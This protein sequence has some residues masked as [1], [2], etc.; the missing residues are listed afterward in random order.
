MKLSFASILTYEFKYAWLRVLTPAY[1]IIGEWDIGDG[2]H[3]T[4]WITTWFDTG[5]DANVKS[6]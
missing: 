2:Y 4:R 5:K 3:V 6:K 1:N